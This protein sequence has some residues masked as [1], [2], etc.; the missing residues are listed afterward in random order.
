MK[1]RLDQA[2]LQLVHDVPGWRTVVTAAD[3]DLLERRL[4]GA[5]LRQLA[6][7]YHLTVAGVRVHL[8]G[9]GHG[10]VRHG[11]VLGCLRSLNRQK[12]K[13]ALSIG[14]GQLPPPGMAV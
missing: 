8:Y 12:A 6:Q 3:A 9:V 2:L 7:A 11:G 14:H 13:G 1:T 10:G 4:E 5:T